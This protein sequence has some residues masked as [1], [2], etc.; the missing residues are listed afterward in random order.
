M[1]FDTFIFFT[2]PIICV[3]VIDG[4]SKENNVEWVDQLQTMIN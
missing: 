3:I 2:Q 4:E 1:F